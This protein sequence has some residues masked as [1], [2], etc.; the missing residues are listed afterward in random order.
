MY[1]L[2]SSVFGS[3]RLLLSTAHDVSGAVSLQVLCDGFAISNSCAFEYRCRLLTAEEKVTNWFEMNERNLDIEIMD[4]LKQLD[5][6]LMAS[7]SS[8][9]A[10]QVSKYTSVC[11]R[12]YSKHCPFL[13]PLLL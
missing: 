6:L 11:E 3:F 10:L 12:T 2:L 1:G 5:K 4:R 9:A 7:N 13:I 8:M